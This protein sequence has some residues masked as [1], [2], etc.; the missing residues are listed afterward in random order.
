LTIGLVWRPHIQGYNSDRVGGMSEDLMWP[1]D[2]GARFDQLY[3]K[4]GS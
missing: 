2:Q 3:I 4:A 1:I